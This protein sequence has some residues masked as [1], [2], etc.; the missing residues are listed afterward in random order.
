MAEESRVSLT[1][2]DRW[3]LG[4]KRRETPAAR[5]A[6]DAYLRLR[7]FNVPDSTI[8]NVAYRILGFAYDGWVDAKEILLAKLLWEPMLRARCERVGERIHLTRAPYVRGHA[9]IL[10]GDDCSFSTLDVHSGRFRDRP[11]LRIGNHCH[12]G[13]D[14]L[15]AVN[16]RVTIGDH[17]GISQRVVVR[18]SDGHP[19]DLA[20]RMR[21]EPLAPEDMAPVT[22]HDYAWVGR[23]AHVLKGVTIGAGAI[24]ASGSVVATDV[25]DGAIAM[26]VPARVIRHRA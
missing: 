26:G 10:I 6:H 20:R 4:V 2:F 18:D 7:A 12:V 23:D 3:L 17:V 9:R 5:M 21:G 16:D 25:P 24:V 13:Y 15:F 22:I 11:E 1:G 19:T 8:T 14:T